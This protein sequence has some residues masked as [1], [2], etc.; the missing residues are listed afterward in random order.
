MYCYQFY[1]IYYYFYPHLRTFL[2]VFRKR[3]R[4]RKGERNIDAKEKHWLVASHTHLD[5]G[6]HVPD[7]GLNPQLRYVP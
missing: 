2:I 1:F 5:W 7:W 3:K 6:S 4:E